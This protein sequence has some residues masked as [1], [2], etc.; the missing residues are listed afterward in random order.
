[1]SVSSDGAF[2]DSCPVT[3]NRRPRSPRFILHAET[4]VERLVGELARRCGRNIL[5]VI[6]IVVLYLQLSQQRRCEVDLR[7]ISRDHARPATDPSQPKASEYGAATA[8]L[9]QTATDTVP[10]VGGQYDEQ[11]VPS[12][13]GFKPSIIRPIRSSVK[14]V[15]FNI[16]CSNLR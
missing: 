8:R 5:A 15:T 3:R 16:G 12:G 14:A 7:C 4:V 9:G 11:I 2:G 6:E 10:V 1:M 13:E